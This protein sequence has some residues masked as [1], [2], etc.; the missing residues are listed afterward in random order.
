MCKIY[1]VVDEKASRRG[2]FSAYITR[3][4]IS[5]RLSYVNITGISSHSVRLSTFVYVCLSLTN[6]HLQVFRRAQLNVR[7]TRLPQPSVPSAQE[8]NVLRGTNCHKKC[9]RVEPASKAGW[10]L[11]VCQHPC[12]KEC[13]DR[14]WPCASGGS[15]TIGH[16]QAMNTLGSS[17]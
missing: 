1:V 6:T 8:V 11:Q 14:L 9:C 16:V 3:A 2:H 12:P 13:G 10:T 4:G 17:F 5:R 7:V 15:F